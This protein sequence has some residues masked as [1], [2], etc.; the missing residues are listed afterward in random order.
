MKRLALLAAVTFAMLAMP[1]AA[2]AATSA[3]ASATAPASALRVLAFSTFTAHALSVLPRIIA[4]SE[5]LSDAMDDYDI[6]RSQ[7]ITGSQK[8]LLSREMAWLRL[9]RPKACFTAVFNSYKSSITAYLRADTFLYRWLGD[10][11]YGSDYD[12]NQALS[13]LKTAATRMERTTNLLDRTS[14]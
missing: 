2:S 13:G 10:F 9:Y 8:R 5:Q 11:P 4:L 12:F 3:T 7:K 6:V 14:C 1:A